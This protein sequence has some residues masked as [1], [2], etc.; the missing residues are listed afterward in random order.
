MSSTTII[1]VNVS[2]GSWPF[3][4]FD[5]KTPGQLQRHLRR[6]GIA[7]AW[8]SAIDSVLHGDPDVHD[9]LLY[10]KLLRHDRLHFVKTVHPLLGDW[11]RSLARW[12]EEK[13]IRAVKIFPG[14]HGY[15][16]GDKRVLEM[17]AQ[18]RR[19]RL[20]LL[21]QM[22]LEDERGQHP[23][24]KVAGVPCPEVVRLAKAFPAVPIVA[25]CAYLPEAGT[26][27]KGSPNVHVDLSFMETLDTLK[28]ALTDIPA[29]QILFG[30]HTPFLYTRSAVLKLAMANIPSPAVRTIAAGNA[31]RVLKG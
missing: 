15:G 10:A 30:S 1:D 28:T 3:Q 25:L 8:V 13:R 12:V 18:L 5:L 6:E 2:L 19:H 7:A 4:R 20:P 27:T 17:M 16:L 21:I 9:E 31:R 22:R 26:L 23:L 11:R 29:G 14:Y 24:M